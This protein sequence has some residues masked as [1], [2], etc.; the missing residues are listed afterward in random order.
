M[1]LAAVLGAC[2]RQPY[3]YYYRIVLSLL[4]LLSLLPLQP[5][6]G[7]R[8]E[9]AQATDRVPVTGGQLGVP[10]ALS[11]LDQGDLE[12]GRN[13][14]QCKIEISE[15]LTTLNNRKQEIKEMM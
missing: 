5:G 14:L 9:L 1:E 8:A 11:R 10:A 2:V 6:P 12:G 15:I 13:W 7:L 3:Y 4:L